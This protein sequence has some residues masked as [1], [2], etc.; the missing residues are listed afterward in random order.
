MQCSSKNGDSHLPLK[1]IRVVTLEHALAGPLCTR[2]LADLGAEVIKIER[3]GEGDFSRGYDD[4][5]HGQ[6]NYFVWLN[7]GKRSLSID[8][9]H[10]RSGA[11]L[12]RLMRSADVMVQNLAPGAT[13]RIGLDYET[14]SQENPRLIVADISGYG[15]GGSYVNKKAYDMLIQAEAGVISINGSEDVPARMGLSIVDLATGLYTH[16]AVLAALVRRG[17]TGQGANVKVAM[18]DAIAEWMTYPM[19]RYA[20]QGG[21]V[22]RLA[23]NNPNIAPYGAH[24][25][26][27]GSVIF[28]IQNEREWRSFCAGVMGTPELATNEKYESNSVRIKNAKALTRCIEQHFSSLSTTEAIRLLDKA[29]IA[30]GRLNTAKELWEHTQLAER[31]RW[32]DV[33]IPGGNTIRALLPPM[34]FTDFEYEMGSVPALGEHT[35][36][37]LS[38]LDFTP[39]EIQEFYEQDAVA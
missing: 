21:M 11:I 7:R 29:G 25:T 20:Y 23:M 15:E 17:Q 5:V 27:D 2:H 35:A 4:H 3:P 30:N 13:K 26:K 38:C 39:S 6:S 34:T 1:G 9:K 8:I 28:S 24:A 37:I 22:P 12:R 16:T 14:L 31:D 36:E 10:E 32:R 18:L 33:R 19:Y